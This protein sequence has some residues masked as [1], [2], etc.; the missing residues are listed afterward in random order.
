MSMQP[1]PTLIQLLSRLELDGTS[2]CSA[3]ARVWMIASGPITLLII[4]HYFT[5]Q[6]QG[7]YFTFKSL[8]LLQVFAEL[9]MGN[10]LVQFASHEWASLKQDAHGRVAGDAVACSRLA[11]LLRF[12]LSWYAV[13]A[14]L[15]ILGLGGG[16]IWFFSNSSAVDIDWRLPWLCLAI[17]TGLFFYLQGIMYFLEGCN[18]VNLIYRYRLLQ[19]ILETLFLWVAILLG[20]GLWAVIVPSAVSVVIAAVLLLR[21]YIPLLRSLVQYPIDQI[22]HWRREIWP[23]QWRIAVSWLSNYFVQGIFNPVLFYYHGPVVAGQMGMSIS[24]AQ[25]IPL[26]GYS[27]VQP[28]IPQLGMMVSTKNFGVLDR[29]FKRLSL[30]SLSVGMAS[31]V[32]I[33]GSLAWLFTYKPLLSA[34][35]L[36]FSLTILLIFAFYL[37]TTS[38][39]M[40]VYLRAHKEEP[41][42]RV[43]VALG[44]VM[45]LTTWYLGANY[46][47][48]GV[49]W[50][51]LAITL[52]LEIPLVTMVFLKRRRALHFGFA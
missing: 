29:Y 11:S 9:G 50:G 34:R 3:L 44:I 46:A 47:G 22:I 42:M 32:A 6:M 15:L 33:I 4:A 1:W 40:G 12:I 25:T 8:L 23:F 37:R 49:V 39:L 45:G 18:Q 24:L 31:C 38:L 7:F 48:S 41:L 2:L 19:T 5:P 17:L 52:F 28:K 16:G 51:F 21:E 26:V 43:Q 30:T 20:S 27:L 13:A 10:V 14:V 35:L 36:P